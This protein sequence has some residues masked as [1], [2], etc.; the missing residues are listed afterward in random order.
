MSNFA[1]GR[2]VRMIL[3][4]VCGIMITVGVAPYLGVQ[5]TQQ[6]IGVVGILVGLVLAGIGRGHT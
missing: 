5:M 4:F 1:L 3:L 2:M 6:D